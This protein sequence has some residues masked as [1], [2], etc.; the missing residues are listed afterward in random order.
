MN[1]EDIRDLYRYNEWANERLA[2]SALALSFEAFNEVRG[3]SHPSLRDALAHIVASEW[4]WLER[5]GGANPTEP[6]VWIDATDAVTLVDEMRRVDA[7]RAAY[8]AG[9]SDS[10]LD[11]VLSFTFMSGKPG[12]HRLRDL[13]IHVANHSTYH[14]GQVASML[15][16]AGVVPPATDFVYY[17]ADCG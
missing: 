10:E 16:Q 2:L 11:V 13:L 15:R 17:R 6:P 7:A 4:V 12:A 5:W 3:G 8:L 14:R 1:C 9:L